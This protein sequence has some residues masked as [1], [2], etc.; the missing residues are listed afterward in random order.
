MDSEIVRGI[1]K[2]TKTKNNCATC[3]QFYSQARF[4]RI[5]TLTSVH[6]TT[7]RNPREHHCIPW[8]A[9]LDSEITREI[10]KTTKT[11]NNFETCRKFYF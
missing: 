10:E 2:N 3:R 11:E 5:R 7:W 8:R 6:G 9:P 4:V 1:E